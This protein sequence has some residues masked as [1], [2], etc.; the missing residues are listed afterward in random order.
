MNYYKFR[1]SNTKFKMYKSDNIPNN[2][3]EEFEPSEAIKNYFEKNVNINNGKYGT[4]EI[5]E[6][7][8]KENK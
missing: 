5:D 2:Y 4:L 8:L 3:W 6:E 1:I 7:K